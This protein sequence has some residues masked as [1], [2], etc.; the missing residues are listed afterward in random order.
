MPFNYFAEKYLGKNRPRKFIYGDSWGSVI[1]RNEAWIRLENLIKDIE[2]EV[3]TLDIVYSIC[4]QQ[5]YYHGFDI[6][7]LSPSYMERFWESVV[8]ELIKIN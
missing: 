1:M 3:F 6:H 5:E 8:Q 4:R 2:N 7:E